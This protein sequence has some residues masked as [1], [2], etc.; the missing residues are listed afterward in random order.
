MKLVIHIFSMFCRSQ[1]LQDEK[2]KVEHLLHELL[3]V[4]VAEKLIIGKTVLPEVF[5]EVTIF[6]SD[7]VSFTRICAAGTPYDVV[8]MLNLICTLFDEVCSKWDVYKVA[9]IGDAYLLASGVPVRNGDR[10]ASEVCHLSLELLDTAGSISIPH[11]PQEN[12]KLRIGIHTG[13]CAAGVAGLKMPRYLLFG[14]TVDVAA[15]MES[16]GESMKIHVSNRTVPKIK[17]NKAFNLISRGKVFIQGM[18]RT[19]TFWLE[20]KLVE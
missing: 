14:E 19:E 6:F 10:H 13:P 18:G 9:T 12:L 20:K 3:P 4:S 2:N 16:N 15:R 8:H 7:I 1:D 5:D 11:I 17:N